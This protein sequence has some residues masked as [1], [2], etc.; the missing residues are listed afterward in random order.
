M[1][2]IDNLFFLPLKG[3]ISIVEKVAEHLD[4]EYYD[5]DNIQQELLKLRILYEMD[6]IDD[7]EY[8]QKEAQLF[9]R[10]TV[11]AEKEEE[12]EEDE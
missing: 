1:F 5:P 2:I 9:Q 11:I 6:E 12:G 8:A 4:R 7:E 10:L 3:V